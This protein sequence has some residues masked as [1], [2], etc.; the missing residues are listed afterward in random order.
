[1]LV[2][3]LGTNFVGYAMMVVYGAPLTSTIHA[4]KVKNKHEK[5][6]IKIVSRESNPSTY[7]FG[8]IEKIKG[9]RD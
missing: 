1:M 3:R 6:G 5:E 4:K 9:L 2:K 8:L 7:V